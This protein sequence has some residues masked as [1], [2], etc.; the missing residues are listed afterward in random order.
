MQPWKIAHSQLQ[1]QFDRAS[2]DAY[3]KDV[4]LIDY[5]SNGHV[6][7]LAATNDRCV[8]MLRHR[9]YR[10]VCRVLSDVFGA[11][12]GVE[13]VTQDEWRSPQRE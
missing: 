8:L 2:F 9:L 6:F 1:I 11:E 5:N 3:L 10:N 13:V 7:K 12:V 4:R